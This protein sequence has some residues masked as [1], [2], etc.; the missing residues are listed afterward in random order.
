ML[1]LEIQK[2]KD[3]TEIVQFQ[4]DIGG[5]VDC[6]KRII[7]VTNGCGKLSSSNTLFSDIWFSEVNTVYWAST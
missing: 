2:G 3:T 5:T 6:T 1:H 4:K 7:R